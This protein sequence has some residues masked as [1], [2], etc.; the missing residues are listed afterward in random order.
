VSP[1]THTAPKMWELFSS[2]VEIVLVSFLVF[3]GVFLKESPRV[4]NKCLLNWG[5]G[6]RVV[7]RGAEIK[8]D[9]EAWG[10]CLGMK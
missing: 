8:G 6:A 2:L 1:C 3:S 9:M 10:L 7:C 4:L 5:L